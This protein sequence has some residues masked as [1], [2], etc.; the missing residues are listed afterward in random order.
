MKQ[1]WLSAPELF[2]V[3]ADLILVAVSNCPLVEN[4]SV[5]SHLFCQTFDFGF[6]VIS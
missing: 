6:S 2:D 4:L 1:L 3:V 5:L